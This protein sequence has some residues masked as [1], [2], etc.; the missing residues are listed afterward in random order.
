MKIVRFK[1]VIVNTH[2]ITRRKH[3]L[4]NSK[5]MTQKLSCCQKKYVF[6]KCIG[7]DDKEHLL[8][9]IKEAEINKPMS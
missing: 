9:D 4:G 8:K 1:Q 5:K 3:A 7:L 2:V 6:G